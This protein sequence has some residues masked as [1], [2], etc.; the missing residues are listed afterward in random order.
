MSGL[1]IGL[2]QNLINLCDTCSQ[3]IPT[4]INDKIS[5]G[6]GVGN[7]NII[8]CDGYKEKVVLPGR[9]PLIMVD[10]LIPCKFKKGD[11]VYDAN[12][13]NGVVIHVSHV[14]DFPVMVDYGEGAGIEYS[15]EGKIPTST[16]VT[17]FLERRAR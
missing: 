14:Q 3:E 2:K 7:D 6:T 5:Y 4:C 1:Y 13:G 16:K 17:L 12:H 9:P 11:K 15:L 10:D 8:E